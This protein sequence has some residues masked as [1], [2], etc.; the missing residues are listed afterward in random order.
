MVSRQ[1]TARPLLTQGEVMQLDATDELVLVSGHGADPRQEAALFRGP[2]FQGADI[3][4]AARRHRGRRLSRSPEAASERLGQPRAALRCA[5]RRQP[6]TPR[7]PRTKADLSISGRRKSPTNRPHPPSLPRQIDALGLEQDDADPAT[8][9]RA[10]DRS[11]NTQG[12]V[13]A[14]PRAQPGTGAT[15]TPCRSF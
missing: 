15:T 12:D 7:H 9:K 10:M 2:A 11:R 13:A 3:A 5:A 6:S 4:A 8:D 1:E 14:R